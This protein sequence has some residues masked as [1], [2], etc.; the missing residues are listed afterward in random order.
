MG[1][2]WSGGTAH[3]NGCDSFEEQKNLERYYQRGWLQ[4]ALEFEMCFFGVPGALN[5]INVLNQSLLLH[6]FLA[7]NSERFL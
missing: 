7:V 4:R 5:D 2:T 1:R 6:W 3:Q